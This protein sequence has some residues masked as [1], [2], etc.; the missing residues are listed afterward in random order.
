MA[1]QHLVQR[2]RLEAEELG[3][4]LLDARRALKRGREERALVRG[5]GVLEREPFGG[6]RGRAR[7][8]APD[9]V[10]KEVEVDHSV[11]EDERPLEDVLQLADVA[12]PVVVEERLHHSGRDGG[13][14]LAVLGGGPG[15]QRLHEEGHVLA[16]FAERR[17]RDR[18]DAEPVE[19]V[20]AEASFRDEPRQV[21]IRGRDDAHVGVLRLDRAH[22]QKLPLLQDAQELRLRLDRHRA[23]LVEEDR[24]LVGGLEQA[25]LVGDRAGERATHVA[26]EVRLQKV[27]RERPGVDR[28]EGARRPRRQ[29]VEGLRDELLAR[30]AL[31]GDEDCRA[32]RRGLADRLENALHR[33]GAAD[34]LLQARRSAEPGLEGAVLGHEL[35]F[36]ERLLDD[37]HDLFVPEGLGQVVK[38]ALAHRGDRA[39][40][41]G[42]RGH[43]D[44]GHLGMPRLHLRED[45]EA[46]PVREH[47]IEE[48]EVDGLLRETLEPLGCGRGF[49]R[50]ESGLRED[51]S[52]HVADD[53]L[54]VEDQDG[55][56]L[57]FRS[58]RAGRR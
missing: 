51:G 52:Q 27:G 50:H 21:G 12:R 47:E 20:L 1:L 2:R 33:R 30:A 22:G 8:R 5:D 24:A 48:Q 40:H 19:E 11:A 36:L 26:E 39:F 16:A 15:K 6:Q 55:G 41:G 53:W 45:L 42:V 54:V 13:N 34:D 10:G 28:H 29:P 57:F 25:L 35:L 3:G 44:D 46:G 14:R 7:H 17:E 23:D 32:R 49:A 38:R 9:R 18:D 58:R 56:H 43:H 37:V 31:A 4:A